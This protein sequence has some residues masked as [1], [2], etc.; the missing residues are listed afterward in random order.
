MMVQIVASQ[1]FTALELNNIFHLKKALK[2]SEN[3]FVI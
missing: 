1:L 2:K 3:N